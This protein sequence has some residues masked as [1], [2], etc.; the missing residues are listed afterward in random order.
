[1]HSVD[2]QERNLSFVKTAF[3]VSNL[4][5]LAYSMKQAFL[6]TNKILRELDNKKVIFQK[7]SVRY[8]VVKPACVNAVLV[9]LPC[10]IAVRDR[11]FLGMQ[12]FD[13]AH[14]LSKLTNLI[15][16]PKF[17]LNFAKIYPNLPKSNQFCPK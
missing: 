16:F 1:V 10:D 7:L 8:L 17:H 12:N 9:F 14:I 4:K 3:Q 5:F 2:D 6:L 13:F 15:T 11:M